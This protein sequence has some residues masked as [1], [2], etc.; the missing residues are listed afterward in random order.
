MIVQSFLQLINTDFDLKNITVT[1][2]TFEPFNNIEYKHGRKDNL[3][4]IVT[5]G[6]RYYSINGREFKVDEGNIIFIPKGTKY[7]T[8][9]KGKCVGT[10]ICFDMTGKDDVI[11]PPEVYTDW[12]TDSALVFE[13]I[14]RM[15]K[16]YAASPTSV[17]PI[18]VLL[19]KVIQTLAEGEKRSKKDYRIIK[20]AIDYISSHFT[21]NQKVSEYAVFCNVSESYFRKLFLKCMGVSPIQYRNE[22]RFALARKLYNEGK[23]LQEIAEMT[24]FYD[25]GF[26]SKAYK[27]QTGTT[28]RRSVV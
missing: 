3:L 24:G 4:H 11:L 15:E 2:Y 19:F 9:T 20:P 12:K 7:S 6:T 14:D 27:K 28:L 25:A 26:F 8:Y 16:I 10:G 18:K 1:P 17:L 5:Y 21:E 22:L 13:C 23:T